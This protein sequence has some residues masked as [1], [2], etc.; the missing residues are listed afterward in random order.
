MT[1]LKFYYLEKCPRCDRYTLHEAGFNKH[2]N[3]ILKCTY[4]DLII[5]AKDIGDFREK[6]NEDN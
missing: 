3:L 6:D 1:D 2:R 4:C 5:L